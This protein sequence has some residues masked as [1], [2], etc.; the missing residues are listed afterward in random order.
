MALETRDV[1]VPEPAI[2]LSPLCD[3]L[4]SR[5]LELIDAVP[6]V[7]LLVNE[8]RGSKNSQVL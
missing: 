2:L 7:F 3:F 8:V 6:S 4:Y 1:L 5:G